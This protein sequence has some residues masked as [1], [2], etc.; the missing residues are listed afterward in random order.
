MKHVIGYTLFWIAVGMII[1]LLIESVFLT[2][3]LIIGLM[4]L[5]FNLFC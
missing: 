4:L 2:V 3:L 5:G 1:S